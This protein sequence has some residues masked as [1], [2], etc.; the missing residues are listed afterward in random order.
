MRYFEGVSVERLRQTISDKSSRWQYKR[1]TPPPS[2]SATENLDILHKHRLPEIEASS[3]PKRSTV[4]LM[5]ESF[6]TLVLAV[7]EHWFITKL[8]LVSSAHRLFLSI[9]PMDGTSLLIKV[10]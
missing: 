1:G 8:W 7:A 2:V 3:E 6:I 10:L 9:L 4:D 5:C